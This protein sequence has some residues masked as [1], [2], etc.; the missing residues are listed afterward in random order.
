MSLA[1]SQ[2]GWRGRRDAE[3]PMDPKTKT[4]ETPKRA[5]ADNRVTNRLNHVSDGQAALDYLVGRGE[6]ADPEKSPLPT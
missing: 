6:F 5:L 3:N 2:G 1:A 4:D